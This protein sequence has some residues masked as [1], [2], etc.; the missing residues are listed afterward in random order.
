M[1]NNPMSRPP[2]FKAVT[3]VIVALVVIASQLA[4]ADTI[5]WQGSKQQGGLL[6]GNI[7]A[8]YSV[9]YEGRTLRSTLEG[10]FLIG[11]GRQAP[12]IIEV[13]LRAPSGDETL[14][15][16]RIAQ[17]QYKIQRVD[18]V[19]Q[20]TVIP[21][22]AELAR[23]R[24]DSALVKQARKEITNDLDFLAGFERP[25]EGPITGVYGSQRVY[26]GIPKSPH[27]GLDYAAPKGTVVRAP[28]SGIVRMAHRDLFYSGGTLI[29]DHGHGLS[30][31][32]LHLS[33]ILVAVGTRVKRGEDIAKVGSTGRATGPHLDWRM[34]WHKQRID[35]ALVL[36][37]LPVESQA[38]T[39]E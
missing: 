27:Y 28:A 33:D 6:L 26:N 24:S 32:F 17:R 5:D 11:L 13:L 30:S 20:K 15:E 12:P 31:T 1:K 10:Q 39:V 3:G 18:G 16:L 34:N 29:I 9:S 25:L 38:G 21:P 23:I 36:L 22:A 14:H 19:P 2:Y 8:G 37:A 4:L 7:P 35:P